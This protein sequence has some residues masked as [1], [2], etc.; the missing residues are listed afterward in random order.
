MGGIGLKQSAE[1]CITQEL[2]VNL[3]I[4]I[5]NIKWIMLI[6]GLLTCSMIF[7]VFA[8]QTALISMFGESLTEPLAQ[9]VVRSWGFLIFIMGTLLIYGAFKPVH[10]NL[11]LVFT[12]ITKIVFIALIVIFGSQ[13]IEKSAVTIVLDSV[14]IIIFLTYLVKVKSIN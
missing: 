5:S 7:A 11:A 3:N 6:A 4:I 1:R 9:V 8:P 2:G 12:S 14:L 13:Y 10:R